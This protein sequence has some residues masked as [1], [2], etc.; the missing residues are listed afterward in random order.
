MN[1]N[2]WKYGGVHI[3]NGT[4]YNRVLEYGHNRWLKV[5]TLRGSSYL[6]NRESVRPATAQERGIATSRIIKLY[7][8]DQV[9]QIIKAYHRWLGENGVNDSDGLPT[10]FELSNLDTFNGHIEDP[11]NVPF[12]ELVSDF[13]QEYTLVD[14]E[15]HPKYTPFDVVLSELN[16]TKEAE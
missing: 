11:E 8:K 10:D 13:F 2:P 12:S 7:T 16:P 9:E 4:I 6:V 5:W 14:E 3:K 15:D 1:E